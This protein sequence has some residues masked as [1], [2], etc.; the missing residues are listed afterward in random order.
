MELDECHLGLWQQCHLGIL[1]SMNKV[2]PF[3]LGQGR[4][5]QVETIKDSVFWVNLALGGMVG[6]IVC[7]WGWLANPE[8]RVAL[9][10]T[11]ITIFLLALFSYLFSL[12]RAYSHFSLISQGVGALG[13]LSTLLVVLFAFGFSDPLI[14]ALSGVAV[15]YAIVIGYWFWKGKY[16]IT[17]RLH[18]RTVWELLLAGFP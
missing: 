9:Q 1:H 18:G 7:C 3:L 14:G 5:T 10:I 12:L 17:F 11:S 16:R 6:I 15:A 8:Y 2:I 4:L 13:V